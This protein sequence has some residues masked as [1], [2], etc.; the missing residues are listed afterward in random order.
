MRHFILTRDNKVIFYFVSLLFAILLVVVLFWFAI[1][2]FDHQSATQEIPQEISEKMTEASEIQVAKSSAMTLERDFYTKPD[3]E[4]S[5][6]IQKANILYDNGRVEEALDVFKKI[7]LYSQSLA[8][9]NLGVI[10]LGAQDYVRAKELFEHAIE[11]GDSVALSAIGAAYSALKQ[12]DQ[13]SFEHFVGLAERTLSDSANTP[14]YSYL[15]ALTSFYKN[16][17]F[18][19]LSPLLHPNSKNY[20]QNNAALASEIF[21][22]LGDDYSALEHLKNDPRVENAL[23]IGMLYARVGD[24]ARARDEIMKYLAAF[25]NDH[26]ALSALELV[27][28]KLRNYSDSA[29]LLEDLEK[30]GGSFFKIR[31]GLNPSLF[32]INEAQK[33]FW[34]LKFESRRSL[35]YKILF[36]YAPYKVFNTQQVFRF[37]AD[38][39]FEW[40]VG[41]VD[42][43][44]D[45]Y[46][47][48]EAFSRINRN[49][50]KGLKEIYAGDLRKALK[51]FLQNLRIHSQ[52]SVLYYNIGLLY[53]Q[54]G[55]FENAFTYFSRAYHL[56]S[57][58]LMAGIFAVMTGKLVYRDTSGIEEML[59]GDFLRVD[60]RNENERVFLNELFA[61]ARGRQHGISDLVETPQNS[62]PIYTALQAILA[63]GEGNQ[64]KI[65]KYFSL[66]REKY[67]NDLT[68]DVMYQVSKHYK[69]NLKEMSLEFSRFFRKGKFSNMHALFYGGSLTRELYVYLAFITGNLSFVIT[70]LQD[71]LVTDE[72]SPIG[73]MQ[74]LGMAY[75]YNQEFEKAFVVYNDL[76]D[77]LQQQDV[78]TKFMGAVAAIG[79]G[80]FSNAVALLQISKID[81]TATLESRYALALLYQQEKNLKSAISLLRT[82]SNKNFVSEFF[83]FEIDSGEI[84]Q[85]AQE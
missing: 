53:A 4:L 24:Y 28:L 66:L 85:K 16:Q 38:G 82:I 40:K 13:K 27:D 36:Y 19:A 74:A 63:M 23:A 69:G 35:Q 72:E 60:F 15:Y 2:A 58:D 61:Y 48:G 17:Y 11:G 45:A 5:E 18:E 79:A 71:K 12:G 44:R 52:H 67:P 84:L 64:E 26:E 77:S 42:E 47:R 81:S 1:K 43:A 70:H 56:D 75:I 32:N 68:T 65:T 33:R 9:Y 10:Y 20:A 14:F 49:I 73:T 30:K 41:D 25:P 51:I 54:L 57:Q 59:S 6:L 8:N 3:K 7:S 76:I 80:H 39:G 31:V 21:L 55:D 83:D 50:A 62:K 29:N 78:G 34:N 37:L 22:M 46:T